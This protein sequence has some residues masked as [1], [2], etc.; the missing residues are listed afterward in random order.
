MTTWLIAQLGARMHYAVPR[1]FASA[2]I[3]DALYTDICSAGRWER[4][5]RLLS[6]PGAPRAFRRLAGRVPEGVP[7]SRIRAFPRFGLA[8]AGR[9]A[10]ARTPSAA[11][12]AHLW[13]GRSFC[14]AVISQGFGQAGAVYTFNSAGLEILR[15]ARELGLTTVVEQ[16]IAPA[17]V[18][19]ALL[20]SEHAAFADWQ[21]R[22]RHN[23]NRAAFHERERAEWE[24][25]DLVVCASPFVRE[26]IASCGGPVGRTAV[27]P[28]GVDPPSPPLLRSLAGRRLRILTAGAAGLRKGTPY[29]LEAARA[30]QGAAVFRL[31]GDLSV[32]AS[33][34]RQLR[35]SVELVGPVPRAA[36]AQH[37]AWADLFLLPTLCEG[38]ATVCYEALA[39]GLPVITTPN[40]GSVVRDG[41]DGFIIPIRD[42]EAIVDAIERILLGRSLLA[43][44]SRNAARRA[45]EFTVEKYGERLLAALA[46]ISEGV[47]VPC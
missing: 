1:I 26:G 6:G 13:A 43:E 41:I 16:T 45:R 35:E 36:M 14:N 25:A 21:P 30:L 28:Y 3:L 34:E 10:A 20:E 42:G 32:S 46:G 18:E 40:A 23:P 44:L 4:P 24:C 47:E 15:R 8:Y 39:A 2:G 17:A 5:L 7:Q 29:L 19:D 37:F 9:R 27:V 22:L 12:A 33:S 31:A 38:S 11:T